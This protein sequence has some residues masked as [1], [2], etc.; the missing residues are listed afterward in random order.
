MVVDL[1]GDIQKNLTEAIQTILDK[2]NENWRQQL[3]VHRLNK[4]ST[5]EQ[6]NSIVNDAQSVPTILSDKKNIL[7]GDLDAINN[8]LTNFHIVEG[9]AGKYLVVEKRK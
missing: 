1:G 8:Q 3:I 2:K 4:S 5:I 6:A 9:T 7:P